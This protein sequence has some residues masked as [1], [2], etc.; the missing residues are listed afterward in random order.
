MSLII[1]ITIGGAICYFY[2]QKKNK[3]LK[4]DLYKVN[5]ELLELQK[6]NSDRIQELDNELQSK[7]KELKKCQREIEDSE[8]FADDLKFKN[9]KAT[10]IHKSLKVEIEQLNSSIREY[11][12]LYNAKKDEIERLKKQL[13]E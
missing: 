8:E 9:S 4:I 11:E 2:F 1:G 13:N 12:M 5:R 3:D 7:N 10:A 6:K